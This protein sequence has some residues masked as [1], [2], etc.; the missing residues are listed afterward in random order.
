MR[1]AG[2]IAS[3]SRPSRASRND[4]TLAC[5]CFA[6]WIIAEQH[7]RVWPTSTSCSTPDTS[8]SLLSPYWKLDKALQPVRPS[9]TPGLG[10]RG[11]AR[12]ASTGR[13]GGA[14]ASAFAS[15]V[16]SRGENASITTTA[17]AMLK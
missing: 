9:G 2:W 11:V 1:P 4:A 5:R 12:K 7:A 15:A 3:R 6:A 14:P 8:Q 13:G 16:A 17:S 10:V